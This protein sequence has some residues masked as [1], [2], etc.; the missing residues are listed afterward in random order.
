MQYDVAVQAATIDELKKRLYRALMTYFMERARQKQDVFEMNPAPQRFWE[1]SA[2]GKVDPDDLPIY[3]V[4]QKTQ[5]RA[6]LRFTKE[7]PV[8]EACA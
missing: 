2:A 5:L 4:S 7:A 8:L 6:N 3:V 1:L